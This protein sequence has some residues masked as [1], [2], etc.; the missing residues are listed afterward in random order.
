[1][2]LERL[3]VDVGRLF[4][5]S[6][7]AYDFHRNPTFM[8]L[9][10]FTI[11]DSHKLPAYSQLSLLPELTHLRI[12]LFNFGLNCPEIS[13]ILSECKHLRVLISF[14]ANM[15]EHVRKE[16]VH[17]DPRY[18]VIAARLREDWEAEARGGKLD[19]WTHAELFI[20]KKRRG[21]I[22]PVSRCWIEKSDVMIPGSGSRWIF[23]PS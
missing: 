5:P 6:L 11:L 17:D 4:G 3:N 13:L 23:L 18:V 7:S 21:E 2:R 20:A 19:S 10:H 22:L 8:G 12:G 15:D 16:A 1:M 14:T 9:T